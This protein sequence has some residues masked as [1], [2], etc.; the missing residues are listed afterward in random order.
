MKLRLFPLIGLIFASTLTSAQE[1]SEPSRAWL[2]GAG[3][4]T[5]S[6]GGEWTDR[7]TQNYSV[8]AFL[9]RKFSSNY[10]LTAEWSYLFGGDVTDREASLKNVFTP[11]GNLINISGSYAQVNINQRATYFNLGVEKTIPFFGSNPNSGL[12][13]GLTGGYIWHWLNVDN[14]GNDSPQIIDEYEK[15]Y[16]R[17]GQ[18][19]MLRESL[20]FIYMSPNRKVN[21]KIS[22]EVS[23]VWS[24]DMRAYYYPLGALSDELQSNFLYGLKLNWYIPIYLGGKTEE[25]YYN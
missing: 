4:S 16:D 9:G 25:Y 19:F 18:G 5:N 15:G 3:I 6:P 21:F 20:G 7:Y 12:N 17:F 1:K 23:Q 2:I 14:V 11:D 10:T 8:S 22:F 24:R 13:L